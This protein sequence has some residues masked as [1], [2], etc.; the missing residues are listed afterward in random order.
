MAQALDHGRRRDGAEGAPLDRPDRRGGSDRRRLPPPHAAA[1]R[2][3]P[4]RPPADHPRLTRSSLH[5]CL[6]RH[7]VSR[8]PEIDGDKPK[9]KR[10]ADYAIGYFHIDI[11]EVQ[12]AEGK[13]HLYVAVDRTSKLAFVRLEERVN[14][15]TASRFLEALIEAVPYHIHT[16]LTDNRSPGGD[17]SDP[18]SGR[19]Q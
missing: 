5:R 10:F 11:A 18:Q 13:L 1:A 19:G 8:L 3:L 6:E 14:T 17:R 7:G 15:D 12:T 4:L 16:V 2:R 9:R